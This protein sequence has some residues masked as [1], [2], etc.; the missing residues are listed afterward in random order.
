VTRLHLAENEQG[1]ARYHYVDLP[2]VAAVILVE[3]N[4]TL[5]LQMLGC[6]LLSRTSESG[7]SVHA[8]EVRDCLRQKTASQPGR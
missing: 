3:N 7:S 4:E 2:E 1:P 8:T 6:E 5:F